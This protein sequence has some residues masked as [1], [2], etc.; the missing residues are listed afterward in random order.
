MYQNSRHTWRSG[1][2][3]APWPKNSGAG[4]HHT[5][6]RRDEVRLDR[7]SPVGPLDEK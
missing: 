7:P 3:P 1:P 6:A 2:V 5:F 4:A